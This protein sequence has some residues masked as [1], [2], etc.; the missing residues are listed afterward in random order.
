MVELVQGFRALDVD[1]SGQISFKEMNTAATK[2]GRP[3]ID[4]SLFKRIDK[5]KSGTVDHRELLRVLYPCIPRRL[6]EASLKEAMTPKVEMSWE[7]HFLP[8]VLNEIAL[9]YSHLTQGGKSSLTF[10]KFLQQAPSEGVTPEEV[11][12]QFEE[13]DVDKDGCLSFKEYA[14]F[15][16]QAFVSLCDD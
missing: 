9:I 6:L 16:K 3:A 2:L 1:G 7:Q 10:G 8:E 5:D 14:F 11:R 4:T 13:A 12:Q 15:M